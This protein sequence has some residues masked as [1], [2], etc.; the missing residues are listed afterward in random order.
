M[1]SKDYFQIWPDIRTVRQ[2]FGL[3]SAN[4]WNSVCSAANSMSNMSDLLLTC[5]LHLNF[6]IQYTWSRLLVCGSDCW[7]GYGTLPSIW[8]TWCW[9]S[10]H[11][12]LLVHMCHLWS[13]KQKAY[14]THMSMEERLPLTGSI[15][16]DILDFFVQ[17]TLLCACSFDDS[18]GDYTRAIISYLNPVVGALHLEILTHNA[19]TAGE[20]QKSKHVPRVRRAQLVLELSFVNAKFGTRYTSC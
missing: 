6:C 11:D 16:F 13:T 17:F 19:S 5:F 8:R 14:N 3:C 20:V 2:I 4:T 9:N 7:R 12:I 18:S 15:V 1:R 10:D